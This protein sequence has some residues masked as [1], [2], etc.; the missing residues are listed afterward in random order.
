MAVLG[1]VRSI[2]ASCRSPPCTPV[3]G[4]GGGIV[5]KEKVHFSG[6]L[7]VPPPGGFRARETSL[8][9]RGPRSVPS[10]GACPAPS[11][12]PTAGAALA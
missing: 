9:C 7:F 3:K 2:L 11:P 4:E 12:E 6:L 10:A 5:C 1:E 8:Q